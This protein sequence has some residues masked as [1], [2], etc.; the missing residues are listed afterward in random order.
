MCSPNCIFFVFRSVSSFQFLEEIQVCV[1]ASFS[2]AD[3]L[4]A[5]WTKSAERLFQT[6]TKIIFSI[7]TNRMSSFKIFFLLFAL[8]ISSGECDDVFYRHAGGDISLKCGV[9]P[10]SDLE[11]KFNDARIF[12]IFGKKGTR[13]K[14]TSKTVAH[15]ISKAHVI[16]NILKLSKLETRDSGVYSCRQSGEKYTVRVVSVFAEPPIASPGSDVELHCNIEGEPQTEVHWLSPLGQQ[17]SKSDQVI[18]LKP[19]TSNDEGKWTCQVKDLKIDVTLA[20]V[21][22]QT[23]DVEVPQG[24]NIVLP[25]SL[26]NSTSSP[27]VVSGNWNADHLS[28]VSF[29][30]LENSYAKGLQWNGKNSS[31]VRFTSG[32]LGTNFDINLINVQRSDEGK[33]VCTVEFEGGLKQ[34]AETM[35][36]VVAGPSVASVK[37]PGQGPWTKDVLGV[38][39]WVWVAVGAS[40]LVLIG[41]I[42]LT[43]L[44]QQRNKQIQRRVR[45][46]R[47]MRQP[48]TAK[49]YCQCNRS[50]RE[51]VLG[52][53]VRPV[54]VSRQQCKTHNSPKPYN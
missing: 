4:F 44:V 31:K 43:V 6:L 10:D 16:G 52:K 42:I 32:Q 20:V 25:C 24:G 35:L 21:G 27:R 46:L 1:L 40:S 23:K 26:S 48:L 37:G 47:S 28:T 33:F 7:Q 34:T 53:R 5:S 9:H 51:V 11:W 22:L 30:A 8:W 54:P 36:K 45:K 50:E 39:L 38:Q 2:H 29:P 12:S 41:L 13:W 19:V 3:L 14:G 17:Y 49:D 15:I 18:S